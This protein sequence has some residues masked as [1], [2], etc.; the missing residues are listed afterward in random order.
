MVSGVLTIGEEVTLSN[1]TKSRLRRGEYLALAKQVR[2]TAS[3]D[4]TTACY[5][6]GQ[7]ARPGDPWVAYRGLTDDIDALLPTHRSCSCSAG[8][9]QWHQHGLATLPSDDVEQPE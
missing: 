2:T 3:S 5:L 9:K 7:P 6:C 4:P 1:T 8:A